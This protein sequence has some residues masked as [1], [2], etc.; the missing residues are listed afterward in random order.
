MGDCGDRTAA[1]AHRS[2]RAATRRDAL[3]GEVL[4][5]DFQ[6]DEDEDDATLT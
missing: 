3:A 1:R 5:E 2:A 4:D 6:T